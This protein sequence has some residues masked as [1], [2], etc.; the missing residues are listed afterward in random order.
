MTIRH[1]QHTITRHAQIEVD[2]AVRP[3]SCLSQGC[4]LIA[5]ALT[6]VRKNPEHTLASNQQQAIANL[7]RHSLTLAVHSGPQTRCLVKPVAVAK[8]SQPGIT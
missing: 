3:K 5:K 8:V 6:L 1:Q 7:P 2:A 4:R